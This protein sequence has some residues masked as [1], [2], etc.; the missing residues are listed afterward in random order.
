MRQAAKNILYTT[1]NSRA[2]APENLNP[3]MPGWQVTAIVVDVLVALALLA[4][5]WFV[6]RKAYLKRKAQE[7][8]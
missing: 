2:Y 3:G 8:V 5:E 6:I 7:T 4:L 1:V